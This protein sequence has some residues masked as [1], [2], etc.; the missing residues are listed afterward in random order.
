MQIPTVAKNT[1]L[2]ISGV[3]MRVD[4]ITSSGV[5]VIHQGSELT[6]SKKAVEEIIS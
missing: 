2:N 4:R 3:E 6:I 1:L 5:V